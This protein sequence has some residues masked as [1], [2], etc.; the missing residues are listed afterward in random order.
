MM[1]GI[2]SP[3]PKNILA[4][5]KEAIRTHDT[6]ATFSSWEAM[7]FSIDVIQA[8]LHREVTRIEPMH[9]GVGQVLQKSLA[10][11]GGEEDV[12]LAP[13]DNRFGLDYAGTPAIWDIV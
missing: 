6:A 3:S 13:E 5:R 4:D 12:I 8:I 10:A 2:Q 7:E 1:A 9:L 11:L